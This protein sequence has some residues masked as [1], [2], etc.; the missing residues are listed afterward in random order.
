MQRKA[1]KLIGEIRELDY[2]ERFRI[3][4]LPCLAYR[5]M[6]GDMIEVFKQMRGR[7]DPEIQQILR[8]ANMGQ[9]RTR[10]HSLKLI[11][12]KPMRNYGKF[13]FSSRVVKIWNSFPEI[14]V[15]A[16]NIQTFESRL[17]RFWQLLDDELKY[18]W[19]K[20]YEYENRVIT[21]VPSRIV[22]RVYESMYNN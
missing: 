16:P 15:S 6:R 19:E 13:M 11:T 17:D 2:Q 14:L 5:R 1:S 18:D 10:G 3:L 21:P 9:N 8:R 20:V 12:R 4:K 22:L 7:Y